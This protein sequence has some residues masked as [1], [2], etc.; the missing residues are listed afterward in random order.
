MPKSI[1]EILDEYY[2]NSGHRHKTK[3]TADDFKKAGWNIDYGTGE[4]KNAKFSTHTIH[5][6]YS[7][8]N[9]KK[10]LQTHQ[11]MAAFA[12]LVSLHNVTDI[13]FE[14]VTIF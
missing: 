8:Y 3:P 13:P 5:H 1:F 14:E 11:K 2:F 4:S 10:D 6:K 9:M 12:F 7:T